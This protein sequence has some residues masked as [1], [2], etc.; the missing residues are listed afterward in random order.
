MSNRKLLIL[1]IVAALMIVWAV[2]QSRTDESPA[3]APSGPS[4]LVQGL[5]TAKV[6][7]IVIGTG[8]DAV[9]LL[10]QGNRFVVGN[11]DNYPAATSKINDLIT[12]CLDIL[13]GGLIT[14]NPANHDE[15]QVSEEK[16][17]SIVKF[18]KTDG[19]IITG[20]AIG[21]TDS[22]TRST[23]VRLLSSYDVYA[24]IEA[25]RIRDSAMDYIEK[26]IVDIGREDVVRVTVTGPNDT[27]TLRAGD[28]NDDNIILENTP[29]AKKLKKSDCSQVLSALSSLSFND[30]KRESDE[31][32]KLKFENTYVSELKDK[33]VYT[34]HIAK[35]HEKNYV[36]CGAEYVGEIQMT[37]EKRKESEEELK[38][39]EAKLLAHDRAIKFTDKHKGWLYEIPDWKAKNFTRELAELLQEEKKGGEEKEAGSSFSTSNTEETRDK[40]PE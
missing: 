18:L 6:G 29:E 39:K 30:V 3:G 23:Y 26:E 34:F 7:S 37:K 35:A 14:S 27:Y 20:V 2:V 31:D 11:K 22:Q 15:L 21:K 33:T 9:R 38:N 28:S 32:R 13:T 24:T 36:K 19:K 17:K 25:P 4:Y 10:R 8:N 12:S 5:D 1:S 16:A 40:T